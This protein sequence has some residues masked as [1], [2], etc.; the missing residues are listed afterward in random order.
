M[1]YRPLGNTGISVSAIGFG[2]FKIGRNENAKYPDRYQLPDESQ[3]QRLLNGCLDLGINY[4]DTAPAYGLSEERIG[5]AIAH[6]RREFVL[7]SKAGESFQ[8]G[9]SRYDFSR[10]AITASVHATLQRLRTEYLDVLFIHANDDDVDV[11]ANTD[12]IETVLDLRSAGLVRAAGFSAKS[13]EAARLAFACMNVLM[14]EYNRANRQQSPVIAAAAEHGLGIVVKKG[15][16]SGHLDAE[17]SVRFVLDNPHVGSLL[18]SSL[19]LQHIREN[20]D[21]ADA[22]SSVRRVA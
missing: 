10:R 14:V 22:V 12:A 3:V 19:N 13:A 21:V 18:I 11:L 17:S 2:A 1:H 20:I 16:A 7:S 15:L 8:Q 9:I 6:R 5:R 4:I